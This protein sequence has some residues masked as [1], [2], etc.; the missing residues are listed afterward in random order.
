LTQAF[1]LSFNGQRETLGKP[2]IFEEEV[3]KEDLTAAYRGLILTVQ[4]TFNLNSVVQQGIIDDLGSSLSVRKA[5]KTGNNYGLGLAYRFSRNT[6]SGVEYAFS[7]QGQTYIR[8]SLG[9]L[10]NIVLKT[11]YHN[12]SV[13]VRF[14]VPNAFKYSPTGV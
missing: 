9:N 12:L 6:S 14:R 4:S 1:S 13:P 7:N 11:S 8:T 3:V 2:N 10:E 5:V